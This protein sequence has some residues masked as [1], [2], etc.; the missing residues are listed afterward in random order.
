MDEEDGERRESERIARRTTH[1]LPRRSARSIPRSAGIETASTLDPLAALAKLPRRSFLSS[2]RG[3][4]RR[5][6]IQSGSLL[7]VVDSRTP[8][9]SRR[10][11][12]RFFLA[13]IMSSTSLVFAH[14]LAGAPAFSTARR[15]KRTGGKVR[16]PTRMPRARTV[17][18]RASRRGDAELDHH[19]L[20]ALL[21][22]SPDAPVDE[23]RLSYRE[24]MKRCHP[25]V[26]ASRADPDPAHL[27]RTRLDSP[28]AAFDE[29]D[30]PRASSPL[31]DRTMRE[32]DA[33]EASQL[34]NRAWRVLRDP[35]SRAAYDS[36]RALFGS[37][38]LFGSRPFDGE[39]L[40]KNARP[41][42]PF[43][44]FVDEGLCIGCRGCAQAAPN[45]FKMRDAYNVAR[46]DVQWADSEEDLD[47]AVA[48]CPK[49]CIHT[50]PKADL[51]L[52]EWIHASQPRQRVTLCSVES[53]S[54]RGKGL[55]ESPFVAAE[56]FERR[57]AEMLRD[58]AADADRRRARERAEAALARVNN[59]V[60][61]SRWFGGQSD[62]DENAEAT[63]RGAAPSCPLPEVFVNRALLALPGY[64]GERVEKEAEAA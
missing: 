46:V 64:R 42:L 11:R 53:M 41:D 37:R 4:K 50:V 40:S 24:R 3:K 14:G 57:R 21:G 34:L 55:E 58:A 18:V 33:A 7:G 52:L 43:A 48:C 8:H 39:P 28:F 62:E 45:T 51:P 29:D 16:H 19:D 27:R 6:N 5:Q 44:L 60:G 12:S 54:G 47:V 36:G 63:T 26:A 35:E 15:E 13:R 59:V 9:T 22:V 10:G 25:D 31:D 30:D 20:Y 49:D 2:S 23:I 17:V 1:S 32:R 38:S 61:L 56:R